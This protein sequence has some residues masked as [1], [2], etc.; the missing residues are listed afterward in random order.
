MPKRRK[1]YIQTLHTRDHLTHTTSSLID[2]SLRSGRNQ[3]W[4]SLRIAR[5]AW[6]VAKQ[7]QDRT[8]GPTVPLHYNNDSTRWIMK[9]D[10]LNRS[11]RSGE[12]RHTFAIPSL[13]HLK[14]FLFCGSSYYWI[15][16][17]WYFKRLMFLFL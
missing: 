6:T 8:N 2:S 7:L 17:S 14:W 5:K 15:I 4:I 10:Q 1:L 13:L 11:Y 9:W 16:S 12:F 3:G